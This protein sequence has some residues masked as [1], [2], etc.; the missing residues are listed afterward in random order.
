MQAEPQAEHAWLQ[1]L[2]GEWTSE[3]E[4]E[5]GPDQP[6]IKSTGISTVT[7]LGG[8]W[9]MDEG[10]WE[11]P[12]EGEARSI[13]TL[14]YDPLKQKFVGTFVAS[15][16]TYLWIYEGTLDDSGKVLTLDCMGPDFA[17]GTE[18][19]H[20]KDVITFHSDDHRTLTSH[21]QGPDGTWKSFMT[22]H[23]HRKK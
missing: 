21:L 2:V 1:K 5:M 22:M 10:V 4:A 7:S 18:L 13:M 12:D 14:G 20:Y 15:M 19:V 9:T 3:S 16:M 17:G 6:K 8:L 11:M 23:Y